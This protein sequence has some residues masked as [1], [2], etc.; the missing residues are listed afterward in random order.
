MLFFKEEWPNSD[1]SRALLADSLFLEAWQL[2]VIL[3]KLGLPRTG[4]HKG[5]TMPEGL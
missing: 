5:W 2:L 3:R 4:K 1:V